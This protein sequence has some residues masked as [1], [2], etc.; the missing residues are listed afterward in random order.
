MAFG[1]FQFSFLNPVK[2]RSP[3]ESLYKSPEWPPQLEEEE[4]QKLSFPDVYRELINREE[5]PATSL[6][7]KFLEK[8]YPEEEDYKP[9]KISRLG[10][11]LAGGLIGYNNPTAGI[12]AG[13]TMLQRPYER[14]VKQYG[15]EGLRLKEGAGI[16]ESSLRNRFQNIKDVA[17]IM[18]Q[19][20]DNERQGELARSTIARNNMLNSEALQRMG[21]E[22]VRLFTDENTGQSYEVYPD[23]K[24]YPLGKFKFSKSE[25]EAVNKEIEE[26]K[27]NL[28]GERAQNLEK[29]RQRNRLELLDERLRNTLIR[30]AGRAN[31]PQNRSTYDRLL[32]NRTKVQGMVDRDAKYEPFWKVDPTTGHSQ[33][34]GDRNN[35]IYQELS[36]VLYEGLLAPQNLSP[37][38]PKGRTFNR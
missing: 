27:S 10:A 33:L 20:A 24:K 12:E 13:E 31:L 22:G 26:F 11:I 29:Q 36:N 7:R 28:A 3:F 8:G 34:T 32:A 38:T 9:T 25:T 18:N 1:P 35:P 6:Y 23:G 4:P 16:E 19:Q 15:M 30:D 5:G 37:T 14:A 2:P 17:T 21:R